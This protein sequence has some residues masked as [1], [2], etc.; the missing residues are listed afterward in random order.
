M[1]YLQK[2]TLYNITASG[3]ISK[4]FKDQFLFLKWVFCFNFNF[5]FSIWFPQSF[6]Y[7]SSES[8]LQKTE[9]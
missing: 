6:S 8:D 1:I 9:S 3:P 4:T 2:S 5:N 7:F